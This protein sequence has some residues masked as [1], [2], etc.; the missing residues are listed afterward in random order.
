ML[1]SLKSCNYLVEQKTC[2]A[3]GLVPQHSCCIASV[4][5]ALHLDPAHLKCSRP[6]LEAVLFNL[7]FLGNAKAPCIS[8]STFGARVVVTSTRSFIVSLPQAVPF[9][10]CVA[11]S[12]TSHVLNRH[13]FEPPRDNGIY[14]FTRPSKRKA[15][16]QSTAC[17]AR[18]CTLEPIY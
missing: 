9:F 2:I 10:L 6:Y 12:T 1:L 8:C 13:T 5:H 15:H 16:R 4:Y 18:P 7:S 3:S 17:Q 14:A 11:P